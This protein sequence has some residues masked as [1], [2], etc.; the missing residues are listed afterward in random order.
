VAQGAVITRRGLTGV[1]PV[2]VESSVPWIKAV[3]EP[4]RSDERHAFVRLV[5]G[6]T[7]DSS[8]T[9]RGEVMVRGAGGEADMIRLPVIIAG[10][11]RAAG[12]AS[13]ILLE[14][15]KS[16]YQ[17]PVSGR[18]SKRGALKSFRTDGGNVEVSKCFELQGKEDTSTI[19]MQVRPTGTGYLHTRLHLLFEGT[20]ETVSVELTGWQNR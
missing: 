7:D 11:G 5:I 2:K 13:R 20:T 19:V 18:S 4:G 12:V 14:D 17:M 6:P 1:G 10:A 3:I 15:G 8:E 16:E 9:A